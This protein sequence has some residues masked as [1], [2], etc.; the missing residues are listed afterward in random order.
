LLGVDAGVQ[1]KLSS[2]VSTTLP[3][4]ASTDL[5]NDVHNIVDAGASYPLPSFHFRLGWQF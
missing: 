1:L 3:P 4:G 2:D 5:Q